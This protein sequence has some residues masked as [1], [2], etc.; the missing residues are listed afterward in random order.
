MTEFVYRQSFPI[1][2]LHLD[3]FGRLKPSVLLYFVQEISGQH[4]AQLG[5]SW[6]ALNEKHLFWAII[7][8]RIAITRMPTAGETLYLETWPMPTTRTAYPRA[9]VAY[10]KNGQEVLRTVALWV[11]MDSNTRTMVL[12][13]K[14]GVSVPGIL[15]GNELDTPGS[16]VPVTLANVTSY[17]VG[18]SQL[19]R[20]GHM[21]NTRY[22]DWVDDLLPATFHE[23]HIPAQINLC[24]LAEAREDQDISLAW[25]TG[26][27][28]ELQ[29]D[30]THSDEAGNS[31]RIFGASVT[32]RPV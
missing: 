27:E 22:L 24:Y 4:A 3:C 11:L 10:D 26:P 15:R 6:E 18:Y 5:T 29:V 28:G 30:A 12:P 7:R 31:R 19:D 21:N 13:G 25:E 8:H 32:F 14:S 2:D 1:E 16:L 9:T 20:N 23:N 17:R